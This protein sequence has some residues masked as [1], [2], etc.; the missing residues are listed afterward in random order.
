[1]KICK[2]DKRCIHRSFCKH[3]E[4]HYKINVNEK[5]DY[6]DFYKCMLST[7]IPFKYLERFKENHER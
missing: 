7:P 5:V 6:I 4:G 3:W 1:M 2:A